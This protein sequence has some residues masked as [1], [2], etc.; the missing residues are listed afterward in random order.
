MILGL[1]LHSLGS[2]L[3]FIR[4]HF[5]HAA[6]TLCQVVFPPFDFGMTWSKVRY[7]GLEKREGSIGK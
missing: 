7:L 1:M 6:T 3:A 4:L 2:L 5:E